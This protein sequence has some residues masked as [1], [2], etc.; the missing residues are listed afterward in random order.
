[1]AF[2]GRSICN[3]IDRHSAVT[4]DKNYIMRMDVMTVFNNMDNFVDSC[5]CITAVCL[6]L[7]NIK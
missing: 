3:V 2:A 7:L 1:M 6:L 4:L 5:N